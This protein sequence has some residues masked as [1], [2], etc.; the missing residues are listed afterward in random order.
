MGGCNHYPNCLEEYYS[1]LINKNN[2]KIKKY[3]KIIKKIKKSK[4][5]KNLTIQ[6]IYSDS[7]SKLGKILVKK[8]ILCNLPKNDIV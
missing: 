7:K 3:K 5:Q 6:K 1:Y 2:K 8:K 4:N